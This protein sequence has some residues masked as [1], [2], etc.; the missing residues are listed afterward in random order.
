MNENVSIKRVLFCRDIFVG[1][2]KQDFP[3][4]QS[5]LK[6]FSNLVEL[7]LSLPLEIPLNEL[8]GKG[9]QFQ[10]REMKRLSP[11]ALSNWTRVFPVL[12]SS[13]R[14][15][16]LRGNLLQDHL[17]SL[18]CKVVFNLSS[19]NVEDCGLT[20]NDMAFLARSRHR[21][22]LTVLKMGDLDLGLKFMGVLQ[23]LKGLKQ[24]ET[25]NLCLEGFDR[26]V[27]DES[28]DDSQAMELVFVIRQQ[29]SRTMKCLHLGG[30]HM[31]SKSVLMKAI[32]HLVP[33]PNLVRYVRVLRLISLWLIV[34]TELDEKIPYL[35]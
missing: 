27:H 35:L 14:H 26:Y 30:G 13:L 6:N 18:F 15:L 31:W 23:I 24:L 28:L 29:F 20:V 12:T 10:P 22:T 16:S 2:Y 3:S 25:L 17:E 34:N 7:D 33:M 19:L 5:K 8:E 21:N 4:W 9:I 1:L 11:C 32:K